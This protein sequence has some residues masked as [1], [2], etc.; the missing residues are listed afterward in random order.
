M[1]VSTAEPFHIWLD[2]KNADLVNEVDFLAVHIL[3]FWNG[4]PADQ[5]VDQV[6]VALQRD[7]EGLSQTSAS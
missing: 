7:P 2:P 5:A 1:P 3:P 4:V 6:M